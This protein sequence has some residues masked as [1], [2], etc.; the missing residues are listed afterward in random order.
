M[1]HERAVGFS[2]LAVPR[3]VFEAQW[4]LA[5]RGSSVAEPEL[6]ACPIGPEAGATILIE[7]DALL[8]RGDFDA[9]VGGLDRERREYV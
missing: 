2:D 8:V 5:S 6:S 1:R 3:A 9:A 4:R 7:A